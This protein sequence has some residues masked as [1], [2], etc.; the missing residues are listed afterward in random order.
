MG[1]FLR[2]TGLVAGGLAAL[3]L[4][5]LVFL[6]NVPLLVGL[7][8]AVAAFLGLSLLFSG[9]RGK[10]V[11]IEGMS[12]AEFRRA[13][14]ETRAKAARVR[15]QGDKVHRPAMQAQIGKIC[16]VTDYILSDFQS[17]P[18]DLK[19][20]GFSL[21]YILDATVVILDKYASL[22]A[23]GLSAEDPSLTR[24]ERE[25]LPQVEKSLRLL[26]ENIQKDEMLDLDVAISVLKQTLELEGLSGKS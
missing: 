15:E 5:G 18:K 4:A 7:A 20:A 1:R 9:G 26:N 8:L 10:E 13:L 23:R 17:D 24:I 22:T 12:A 14:A 6:L 21:N 25:V 16:Q 3:L 19:S 11:S 2:E